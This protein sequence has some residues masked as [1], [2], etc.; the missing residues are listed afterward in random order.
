MDAALEVFSILLSVVF[1]FGEVKQARVAPF[2]DPINSHVLVVCKADFPRTSFGAI[3]RGSGKVD[4]A[5]KEGGAQ[6]EDV[7]VGVDDLIVLADDG[8]V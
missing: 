6:R 1:R 4:G 3:S 7:A 2:D 8:D 5:M